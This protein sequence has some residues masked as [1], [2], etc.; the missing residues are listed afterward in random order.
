VLAGFALLVHKVTGASLFAARPSLERIGVDAEQLS[1]RASEIG[2][3]TT[4]RR[5]IDVR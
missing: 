3:E 1:V 2:A 5:L 4:Q